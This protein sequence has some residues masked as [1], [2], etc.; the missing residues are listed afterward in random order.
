MTQEQIQN[1]NIN[2][3]G[4]VMASDGIT[5]E[6]MQFVRREVHIF[7]LFGTNLAGAVS[8]VD[9]FIRHAEMFNTKIEWNEQTKQWMIDHWDELR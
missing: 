6:Q 4:K 8:K 3:A 1:T 7:K 9:M 5:H 2:A